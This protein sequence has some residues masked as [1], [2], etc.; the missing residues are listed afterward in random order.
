MR[1]IIHMLDIDR[2]EKEGLA[3]YLCNQAVYPTL[4]RFTLD[5]DRVTCR[6]CR[7]Y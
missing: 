7:G 3:R 6:N 2:I 5:T 1:K 4:G